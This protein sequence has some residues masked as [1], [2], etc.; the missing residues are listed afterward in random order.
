MLSGA[1]ALCQSALFAALPVRPHWRGRMLDGGVAGSS[2]PSPDTLRVGAPGRCQRWRRCQARRP[3][4]P[5]WAS[6]RKTLW[7]VL[8]TSRQRVARDLQVLAECGPTAAAGANSHARFLAHLPGNGQRLSR[9]SRRAGAWGDRRGVRSSEWYL[10]A[11]CK[12]DAP[13]SSPRRGRWWCGRAGTSV[14]DM[15]QERHLCRRLDRVTT[16]HRWCIYCS[17]RKIN[18]MTNDL[19]QRTLVRILQLPSCSIHPLFDTGTYGLSA[20]ARKG[21]TDA[22]TIGFL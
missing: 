14:H 20:L 16:D 4:R 6:W 2:G 1:H 8:N 5:G 22:P 10:C 13:R 21:C 9:A 12:R 18:A 17:T 15:V 3:T 11:C 19:C 7:S